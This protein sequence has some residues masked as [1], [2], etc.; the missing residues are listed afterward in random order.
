M[1][2]SNVD[3]INHLIEQEKQAEGLLHEAQAE[4]ERRIAKARAEAERDYKARYDQVIGG[5]EADF[6]AQSA[7]IESA[8]QEKSAEYQRRLEALKADTAAF[9]AYL[10]KLLER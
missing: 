10:D 2:D 6:K 1:A 7:K 5:L 4:A 8:H 9:N 3:V